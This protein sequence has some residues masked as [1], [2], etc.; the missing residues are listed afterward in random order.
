MESSYKNI[1]SLPSPID[2]F[3][4]IMKEHSFYYDFSAKLESVYE[5]YL[6]SSKQATKALTDI[7]ITK[8]TFRDEIHSIGEL[9]VQAK[10]TET[11]VNLD[12]SL[13]EYIIES[14]QNL[15]NKCN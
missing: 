14:V 3:E 7:D 9:E 2:I 15:A 10:H 4:T 6:Q 11:L 5:S 8:E 1:L 12:P 13:K